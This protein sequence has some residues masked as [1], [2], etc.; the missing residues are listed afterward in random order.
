MKKKDIAVIGLGTFGYELAMQLAKNGHHVLVVDKDEKKV[1]QIK[2]DVDIAIVADI[3]DPDVLKKIQITTFDSVILSMSSNLESSILSIVHMKKMNV[4]YI[5][6][7]ANTHIQQE[8]LLKIGADEVILP[9]VSTAIQLAEK[10]THPNIL[11]E[12]VVN[13]DTLLMEVLIPERFQG[14]T[15]KELD[16]RRKYG[17]NIIMYSRGGK[18]EVI[19]SPDFAFEKGDIIFVIGKESVIKKTLL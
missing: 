8:I 12:F 17:L 16:L 4:P 3:T 9:E 14:K 19:S 5:I 15:L 13:D 10:I 7:K 11:E 18:T 6:G 2:D 1:N